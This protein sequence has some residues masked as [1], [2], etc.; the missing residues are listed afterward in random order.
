MKSGIAIH[1]IVKGLS[2]IR[3]EKFEKYIHPISGLAIL[4][5]GMAVLFI[6]I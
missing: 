2:R 3:T 1:R 4:L 5:C 6:G